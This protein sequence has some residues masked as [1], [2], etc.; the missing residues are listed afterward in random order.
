MY[1]TSLLMAVLFFSLSMIPLGAQDEPL[2]EWLEGYRRALRE[3]DLEGRAL[4]SVEDLH[5]TG[6]P[7]D[8][9]ADTWRLRIHG[10]GVGLQETLVGYTELLAMTHQ[11]RKALLVCPGVFE[12]YA[13]WEGVP[14]TALLR[15][16]GVESDF[17]S[18][19]IRGLDGYEA[20]FS[21]LEV[22]EY[23]ILLATRVNGRVLPRDHGF[24]VRIVAEN[25]LGGRWVKW[26]SE[27]VVE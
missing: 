24:P 21:R 4:D 12:D 3:A 8:A 9:N 19:L 27:L 26:V 18:V 2:A 16:A 22:E 25:L 15:L 13:E 10:H 1:R 6:R 14:L 23:L 20:A 5:K 17:D 7:Q 11:K